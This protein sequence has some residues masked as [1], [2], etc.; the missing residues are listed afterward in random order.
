MSTKTPRYDDLAWRSNRH[1]VRALV[2][3]RT[4]KRIDERPMIHP[5]ITTLSS[6]DPTLDLRHFGWIVGWMDGRRGQLS[7]KTHKAHVSKAA[8]R[9]FGNVLDGSYLTTETSAQSYGIF[10]GGGLVQ[11]CGSLLVGDPS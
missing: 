5:S 10:R 7:A 9:R 8:P 4:K 3:L 2:S 6:R 1:Q 11:A